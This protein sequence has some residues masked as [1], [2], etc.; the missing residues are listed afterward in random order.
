MITD[1]TIDKDRSGMDNGKEGRGRER[2]SKY[3][4]SPSRFVFFFPTK[5]SI[6]SNRIRNVRQG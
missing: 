2:V 3:Q 1:Q 6:I 4:S 5:S